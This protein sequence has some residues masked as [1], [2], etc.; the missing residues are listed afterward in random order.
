MSLFLLYQYITVSVFSKTMA[1]TDLARKAKRPVR[2]PCYFVLTNR[3]S[4]RNETG[5]VAF[6]EAYWKPSNLQSE[7]VINISEVFFNII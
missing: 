6:N 5:Q 7:I 2:R 4:F 1:E 3:I